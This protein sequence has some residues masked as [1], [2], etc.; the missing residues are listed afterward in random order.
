MGPTTIPTFH[1]ILL[2]SYPIS[3][4]PCPSHLY[5]NDWDGRSKNLLQY[6]SM[7][8]KLNFNCTNVLVDFQWFA[9]CQLDILKGLIIKLIT[10][11]DKCINFISHFH[12]ISSGSLN[13]FN[14]IKF[15]T[16]V[17]KNNENID[18]MTDWLLMWHINKK[19]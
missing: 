6:I 9:L 5:T 11:V 13:S 12:G 10:N 17:K 14:N 8:S 3:W 16:V 15:I 2:I 7:S 18:G 4:S 19:D 1:L